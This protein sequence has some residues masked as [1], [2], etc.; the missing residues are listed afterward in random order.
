MMLQRHTSLMWKILQDKNHQPQSK[1]SRKKLP[2]CKLWRQCQS[3]L[4]PIMV[5]KMKQSSVTQ[6][7][8]LARPRTKTY[9]KKL[10]LKCFLELV[11]AMLVLISSASR[12][13]SNLSNSIK[14]QLN[15]TTSQP[16]WADGHDKSITDLLK[17]WSCMERNGERFSN[18]WLR[19]QVLRHAVMLKSSL[20]NLR[21]KKCL[22]IPL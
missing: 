2:S 22:L 5:F 17:L 8:K 6:L 20:S 16:K 18:M 21:R 15:L 11:S 7:I 9:S 10:L 1:N 13:L 4:T 19:G 14:T 3:K 12:P